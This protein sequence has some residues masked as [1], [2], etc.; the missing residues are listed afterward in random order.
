MLFNEALPRLESFPYSCGLAYENAVFPEE[1]RH[2]LFGFK[3]GRLYR[4]LFIIRGDLVKILCIRAPGER[5]IKPEDYGFRGGR[6]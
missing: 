4:A 6:G 5:P 3:K 1:L 2:L